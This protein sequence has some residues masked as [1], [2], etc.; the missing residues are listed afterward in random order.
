MALSLNSIE[1]GQN[2]LYLGVIIKYEATVITFCGICAMCTTSNT[3][4]YELQ[5]RLLRIAILL[6]YAI[7]SRSTA[8]Q[9]YVSE[10]APNNFS[11]QIALQECHSTVVSCMKTISWTNNFFSHYCS[12]RNRMERSATHQHSTTPLTI[13]RRFFAATQIDKPNLD[14]FKV[15]VVVYDLQL[16]KTKSLAKMNKCNLR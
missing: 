10:P 8:L 9:C 4:Y 14:Y 13:R 7:F 1:S 15:E 6:F 16:L 12:A 5:Y 11:T 3:A 2:H